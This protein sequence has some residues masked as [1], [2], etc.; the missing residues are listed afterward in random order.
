ENFL[1]LI[2]DQHGPG[3]GVR[4]LA[5]SILG[6]LGR[7]GALKPRL[8]TVVEELPEGGR[9]RQFRELAAGDGGNTRGDDVGLKGAQREVVVA[10]AKKDDGVTGGTQGGNEAGPDD[11]GFA[12]A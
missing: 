11:R 8:A 1:E 3:S 12:V 2:E 9:I 4:R 10:A 7:G 6:V 5:E